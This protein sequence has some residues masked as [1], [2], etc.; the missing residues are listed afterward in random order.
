MC[1]LGLPWG[2]TIKEHLKRWQSAAP[3]KG[4]GGV[5]RCMKSICMFFFFC[6]CVPVGMCVCVCVCVC[7]TWVYCKITQGVRLSSLHICPFLHL[8]L[9]VLVQRR[10]G[11]RKGQNITWKQCTPHF[12]TDNRQREQHGHFTTKRKKRENGG[13][14]R[15]RERERERMRERLCEER[16]S[17]TFC[18]AVTKAPQKTQWHRNVN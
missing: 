2:Q 7:A 8:R 12:E 3:E 5:C 17:K 16:L 6:A 4:R 14:E 18:G 15:E 9:W 13:R 10:R 11:R 1:V